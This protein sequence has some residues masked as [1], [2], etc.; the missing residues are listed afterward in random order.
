MFGAK[1]KKGELYM[2][3]IYLL[4]RIYVLVSR[5]PSFVFEGFQYEVRSFTS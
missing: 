2:E 5:D 3:R 4:K 1:K